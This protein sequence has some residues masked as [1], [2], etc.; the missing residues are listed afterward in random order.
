[1][2]KNKIFGIAIA[3][4]GVIAC[5]GSAFA[6][7]KTNA[8]DTGFGIGAGAYHGSEGLVT[9][10]MND[11]VSGTI[12]PQYWNN[13]GSDK[14]GAGLSPTYTQVVYEATLSAVFADDLNEQNFVL[15]QLGI[16]LGNIPEEY[17]GHLSVWV[18]IDGYEADSLGKAQYEKVFMNSDYAIDAEHPSYE[19]SKTIAVASSGVQKV[20][21]FLKYYLGSY[22]LVAKNEASL[23][24]NL[25]LTWGQ[26]DANFEKAYVVGQGNQWT[27][28]DEFSMVP[29]INK[30]A[31]QGWEWVYNNLPGTLGEAKCAKPGQG[32][33]KIYSKGDNA[34]L[35]GNKVYDVYWSGNGYVDQEHQGDAALFAEQQPQP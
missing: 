5:A 35:D 7:Y 16:T 18:D 17:R 15:G 32:E 24:Y 31:A 33:N 25:S 12:N 10:K 4:F 26:A 21:V 28:D 29:N 20:R 9:Y 23:G 27:F 3:S 34:D 2:K 1:M 8:T 30:P 13:D 19:A 11:S 22:D 14:L 6:L